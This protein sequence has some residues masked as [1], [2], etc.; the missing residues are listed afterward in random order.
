M[1]QHRP[2]YEM[3][4]LYTDIPIDTAGKR[5]ENMEKYFPQKS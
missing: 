3:C 4:W 2:Q 5:N 1:R